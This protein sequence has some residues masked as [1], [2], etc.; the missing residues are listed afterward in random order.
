MFIDNQWQSILIFMMPQASNNHMNLHVYNN[1]CWN[2]GWILQ[3][4]TLSSFHKLKNHRLWWNILQ[5][6]QNARFWPMPLVTIQVASW[7]LPWRSRHLEALYCY[8][9]PKCIACRYNGCECSWIHNL[10]QLIWEYQKSQCKKKSV[11][12]KI[13]QNRRLGGSQDFQCG[14]VT[15]LCFLFFLF[16]QGVFAKDAASFYRSLSFLTGLNDA[17]WVILRMY[18][19]VYIYTHTVL[20]ISC[21]SDIRSLY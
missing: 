11:A 6:H 19:R 2:V 4:F 21:C 14:N 18:M 10:Y 20:C 15:L 7:T 16:F 13:G 1:W 17:A 8:L 5:N 3:Y 9:L 12:E